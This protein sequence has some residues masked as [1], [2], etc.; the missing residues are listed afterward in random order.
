MHTSRKI[1]GSFMA[2]I[3]NMR[4]YNNI[5]TIYKSFRNIKYISSSIW[6][7]Q[8]MFTKKPEDQILETLATIRF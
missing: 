3:Q 4:E 8:A 1:I 5:R 6:G 7:N 2:H